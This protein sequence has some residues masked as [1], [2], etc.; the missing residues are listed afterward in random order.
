MRLDRIFGACLGIAAIGIT[1]ASIGLY[2]VTGWYGFNV[3]LRRGGSAWT[4]V[5]P[6]DPRL[7]PAMRLALSDAVPEPA[8]SAPVWTEVAP[9]FETAE[10]PI[11]TAGREVDRILL[12]RF[13]PQRWRFETHNH[14]PGSRG[15]DEWLK[16][17]G[18]SF[19]INGSYFEVTGE[20]SVP[21]KHRGEALGPAAYNARHGVFV[22]SP[23]PAIV[24]LRTGD[25]QAHLA[26]A[27][28]GSVSYP[29]LIDDK[30]ESRVTG[31]DRWLA[32]RSF[33]AT[34][35]AGRV[36]FGTTTDA[37]FSLRRLAE[38]LRTAP[39]GLATALNFD[40]GPLACQ[41]IQV[42]PHRRGFCGTWETATRDGKLSLLRPA[43]WPG[44][45]GL[46]MVVAA[47]P[48]DAA[49]R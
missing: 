46:A 20:P 43:L 38:Y 28:E 47:F 25:W 19:V 6:D 44:R 31:N 49:A 36:I 33:V 30:G 39:L 21:M 4:E 2:A 45:W 48:K 32:N 11:T 35:R 23:T 3:I 8:S 7:S 26:R 17:L 15:P 37:F 27:E 29:L 10:M 14:P 12:T 13:D 42:G 40:G 1:A 16:A 9:G 22:A 5:R 18:A 34:D 24:D 41:G